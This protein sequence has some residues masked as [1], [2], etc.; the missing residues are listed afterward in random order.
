MYNEGQ[1]SIYAL[2]LKA[3][4]RKE[5]SAEIFR[6]KSGVICWQTAHITRW[7]SV[8]FLTPSGYFVAYT[9]IVITTDVRTRCARV[10]KRD[11]SI[12]RSVRQCP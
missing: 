8:V 7:I 9:G 1:I 6:Y 5:K 3:Y 12:H 10:M 11:V 2:I 4:T